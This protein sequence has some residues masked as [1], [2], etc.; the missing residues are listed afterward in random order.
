VHAAGIS[1]TMADPRRIFEVNLVGTQ[2]MLDAFEPLASDL[3]AAVCFSSSA[4]YQLAP[5]VTPEQD[6]LLGNPLDPA[7]LD[8]ASA[9][10]NDSGYAYAMSKRGVISAVGRASVTWGGRG[11]RVNSVAP[12]VINTPMGR[13]EMEQQPVMRDMVSASALKR[14]GEAAEVASVV[15]FLL[16]EQAS[17]VSGIDILVDGGTLQ[18]LAHPAAG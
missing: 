6:A 1:P 10:F 16:S 14:A 5:F 2:L 15:A 7:F 11:A 9:Q 18:G 3:T 17:Y 8:A 12:G 4:A 13:R